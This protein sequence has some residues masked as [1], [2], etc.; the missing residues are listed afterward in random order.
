MITPIGSEMRE[1]NR[2][3]RETDA[4]YHRV[5]QGLG[6]SDSAFLIFYALAE[7]GDG[8]LQIDIAKRYS[9]SK[10]TVSSAVRLLERKGYLYLKHGKKRDMHLVL[11]PAGEAFAKDNILPLMQLEND[12]F[13]I[14]SPEDSRALLKLTR[15]YTDILTEKFREFLADRK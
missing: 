12:V 13:S 7:L 14:M 9:I 4:L 2:M 10:Q 15:L 1:Y 11:T 3:Y 6:L 8:C 5:A